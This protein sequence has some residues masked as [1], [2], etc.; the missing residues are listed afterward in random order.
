[1]EIEQ[2]AVPVV[3]LRRI[4][5]RRTASIPLCRLRRSA[6][7]VPRARARQRPMPRGP[8]PHEGPFEG[9][10]PR[11]VRQTEAG[12]VEPWKRRP[13]GHRTASPGPPDSSTSSTSSPDR[14]RCS[15]ATRGAEGL[16]AAVNLAAT[17]CY[18]VVT[19]LFFGL[20][21]P[22]DRVLSLVAAFFSLVGCAI[23]RA[24]CLSARTGRHRSAGVLRS[25][26]P[27]DR[28]PHLPLD[29][30]ARFP[31]CADDLRWA[32]VAD[33]RVADPRGPPEA[34]QLHSGHP[35][36]DRAHRVAPREGRGRREL[37]GP[38]QRAWLADRN[39]AILPPDAA[40]WEPAE[41][42]RGQRR[43]T[44]DRSPAAGGPR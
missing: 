29:V 15:L 36:R 6:R 26:L 33:V 25:V 43:R 21:K 5:H 42:G 44:A 2:Q 17:G 34:L 3:R 38:G 32:R 13:T 7:A 10:E 40:P 24:R 14:S 37:E 16:G 39:P 1:M 28:G 8:G 23:R 31:G 9:G 11:R 22:V 27:A 20:F 4:A 12:G 35:R 18:V 19:L 41:T 30:P